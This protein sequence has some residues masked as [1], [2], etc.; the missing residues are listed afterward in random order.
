[1]SEQEGKAVALVLGGGAPLDFAFP[2]ER[3]WP[4][5]EVEKLP[6]RTLA[7]IGDAVYELGV[8]LHHVSSSTDVGG[9]LHA[10]VVGIVCAANQARLFVE[11]L[12]SLPENEQTLLKHWR[13]AKLPSRPHAGSSKGEYARSTAFEAWVGFLFLT[14]QTS[15]LLEVFRRARSS[16][17][18]DSEVAPTSADEE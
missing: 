18:T 14:G 3:S 10:S 8:R 2:L 9:K 15:R 17:G 12:A 16:A 5:H 6:T 7:Y 11:I 13:N 1:M 4:Q